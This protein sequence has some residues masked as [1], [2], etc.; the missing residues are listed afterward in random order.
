M[1]VT[2]GTHD[3]SSPIFVASVE[4]NATVSSLWY[5]EII[6]CAKTKESKPYK[7]QFLC[8]NVWVIVMKY[9]INRILTL[10][11]T[12]PHFDALKIYSCGKHCEKRTNCL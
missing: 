2:H 3:L 10:Y 5:F 6:V 4:D 11:H 7:I 12:M 1:Y 9:I 8:E